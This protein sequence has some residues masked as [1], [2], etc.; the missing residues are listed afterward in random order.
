MMKPNWNGIMKILDIQ[1]RDAEGNIIWQDSNIYNLLHQDG[2]EYLLRAAFQGG[3]AST[4]IPEYYYLGMDNRSFVAV[5]DNIDDLV[6]E[7][8]YSGYERQAV[9]SQN[10]F[11]INFEENHFV[12]TSPIVA[13]QGTT[14]SWGPVNNL[15][16]TDASDNSGY[17]IATAVLE[18]AIEVSA[19]DSITVRIGMQLRDCDTTSDGTS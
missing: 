9:H 8:S 15:F 1:H 4:I 17:L 6:G 18:T 11:S 12:A 16:I 10:D 2:E 19:G 5:A 14:G 7:P 3:Q 13:F